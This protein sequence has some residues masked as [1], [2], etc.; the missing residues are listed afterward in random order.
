MQTRF[1]QT[2]YS[3][4]LSRHVKV[5]VDCAWEKWYE[6]HVHAGR[7]RC[8]CLRARSRRILELLALAWRSWCT[9]VR[10]CRLPVLTDTPLAAPPISIPLI[11]SVVS[12]LFAVTSA[13]GSR[14]KHSLRLLIIEETFEAWYQ[15]FVNLR[16]CTAIIAHQSGAQELRLLANGL[17]RW[18]VRVAM[19]G[20]LLR[21]LHS[22]RRAFISNAFGC[23]IDFVRDC[24][25]KH[26]PAQG[27]SRLEQRLQQRQLLAKVGMWK[28]HVAAA[29]ISCKD[30][31]ITKFEQ[32]ITAL[33]SQIA[34]LT[35]KE[36]RGIKQ[37]EGWRDRHCVASTEISSK[38]EVIKK[39]EERIIS[40][41][42]QVANCQENEARAM[43]HITEWDKKHRIAL[44]DISSR[45]EDIRNLNNC[46]KSW[47]THIT[48]LYNGVESLNARL[49]VASKALLQERRACEHKL[50]AA[51][52][53][54]GGE[55]NV[56]EKS[57]A[58]AAEQRAVERNALI[59]SQFELQATRETLQEAQRALGVEQQAHAAVSADLTYAGHE[60]EQWIEKHCAALND[61]ESK[62]E[63]I[64]ES[65]KD[66]EKLHQQL[67]TLHHSEARALAQ[68]NEWSEKHY[69]IQ[70]STRALTALALASSTPAPLQSAP[71]SP[72]S[73]D[74]RTQQEE[75][76]ARALS[77]LAMVSSHASQTDPEH[78]HPRLVEG[79]GEVAVQLQ[80]QQTNL[81]ALAA[82]IMSA[83]A[84][85]SNMAR[86]AFDN[87][88][89]KVAAVED[90]LEQ[91][92]GH[93]A[94]LQ[95]ELV[96]AKAAH[97]PCA[98]RVQ[99]LEQQVEY[100]KAAHAPC[101][102]QVKALTEHLARLDRRLAEELEKED[103]LKEELAEGRNRERS[104]R[105]TKAE[106]PTDERNL[107]ED[108]QEIAC[109]DAEIKSLQGRLATATKH[110]EEE[111]AE[112]EDLQ[113][114]YQR[115]KSK[116]QEAHQRLK[117]LATAESESET[118]RRQLADVVQQRDTETSAWL[119]EI[120]QQLV[121]FS[122]RERRRQQEV[123]ERG[124]CA[125]VSIEAAAAA[126]GVEVEKLDCL[127]DLLSKSEVM[128]NNQHVC[129]IRFES[130][131]ACS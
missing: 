45:D 49:D 35:E 92:R 31:A 127:R 107:A 65:Q 126:A 62:D 4:I 42:L 80:S 12:P 86:G 74:L 54:V 73:D 53:V 59:A 71:G 16:F 94:K 68:V 113:T 26:L 75:E 37:I 131:C 95:S 47:D 56:L 57:Q 88:G 106:L 18:R 77:R 44:A 41:E 81:M 100:H 122:E 128:M 6:V 125:A 109:K 10:L 110:L 84:S 15:L 85:T 32:D 40:L 1:T 8:L 82:E 93:S 55:R 9:D 25:K 103:V 114:K 98:S 52:L 130:A 23:W 20:R 50:R 3:K 22:L 90:A 72:R 104:L 66:I 91:V 117:E 89:G 87:L 61:L 63:V 29:C 101:A 64:R 13:A 105:S 21:R 2:M 121:S 70:E 39:S 28:A 58:L 97:A 96:V 118:L 79:P 48:S 36:A 19:Q 5:Q 43:E 120:R 83:V 124:V 11:S 123:A 129:N 17:A 69:I 102:E 67:E 78:Q 34:D 14:I 108:R 111:C 51:E 76:F 24:K 30:E 99:E 112:H 27:I 60:I 7:F 116:L 38:D 33:E 119:T 46:I 115:L